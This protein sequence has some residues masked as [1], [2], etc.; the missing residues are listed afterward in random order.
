VP[1]QASTTTTTTTSTT[2]TAT[3]TTTRKQEKKH[4]Q[5]IPNKYEKHNFIP[6]N[7]T[8]RHTNT[9]THGERGFLFAL[10]CVLKENLI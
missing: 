1:P 2:S 6:N 5:S 7:H 8:Q 10:K 4:A 3:T 9:H